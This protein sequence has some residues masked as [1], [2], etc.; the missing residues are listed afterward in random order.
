MVG[1]ERLAELTPADL[2]ARAGATPDGARV[3]IA[4]R[5]TKARGCLGGFSLDN[6]FLR[7]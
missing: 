5:K 2:V 4:R 1:I 7:S 6:S 3:T